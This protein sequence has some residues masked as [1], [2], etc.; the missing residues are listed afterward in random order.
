[1]L[2]RFN[3]ETGTDTNRI[4]IIFALLD[5]IEKD[6][7]RSMSVNARLIH[8]LHRIMLRFLEREAQH[9]MN[10]Q[11]QCRHSLLCPHALLDGS[12]E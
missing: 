5:Y 6:L 9:L 11:I 7:L 12:W 10:G 1:M 8:Q 3:H 4:R 2:A